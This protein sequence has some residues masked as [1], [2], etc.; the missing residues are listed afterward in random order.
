MTSESMTV[1]RF[2]KTAY[3]TAGLLWSDSRERRME[4]N[5][6]LQDVRSGALP[7]AVTTGEITKE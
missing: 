4:S 6:G 5:K 3:S 1:G 2:T 7:P